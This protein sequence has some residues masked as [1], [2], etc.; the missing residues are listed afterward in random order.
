M[1]CYARPTHAYLGLSPGLDFETRIFA[2]T[3]AATLLRAELARPSYVPG[4]IVLGANTDPYQP[5]ERKL[6]LTRALLEVL[7]ECRV[8]VGIITKS[9]LVTR[10]LDV[11]APMAARGLLHVCVSLTTLDPAL[12]RTLDPRASAPH[13]RLQAMRELAHAGVPVAV[14][15]SPM[16]PAINDVELEQILQAAAE[17]GARYA[18]YVLL[19]LPLEVRDLFLQW[20]QQHYP[21]RAAH[22]MQRVQATRGGRD[23][24]ANFATRMKGA[25][26]FADLLAQRFRVALK[27][28]GL[29]K[30]PAFSDVT[31]FQRPSVDRAQCDLF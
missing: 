14:F 11:L 30:L 17:A 15:A 29:Q 26:V 27:R 3:N 31:Q 9:A 7:S 2:K 8:P 1:Y 10:D 6:G 18:S 24:D 23:Y 4:L 20:L 19:R 13:S 21:L 25:G 12:A 22:V 28:Y 16:I 5:A